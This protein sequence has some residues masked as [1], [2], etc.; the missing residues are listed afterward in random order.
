[1]N[2]HSFLFYIFIL[3]SG[4]NAFAESY[5]LNANYFVRSSADFGRRDRNK[6]G[7]LTK[8]STFTVE[9]PILKENPKKQ[10][11]QAT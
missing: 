5:L 9:L 7:V 2:K 6:I 1:M 8:G 4:L 10:I 11:T 3:F